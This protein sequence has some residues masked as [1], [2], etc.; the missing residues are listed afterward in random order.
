MDDEV[1]RRNDLR[2][3]PVWV[4]GMAWGIFGVFMV[5][6]AILYYAYRDTD[7]WYLWFGEPLKTRH[8]FAEAIRGSIFRTQ[9]NTWSNVGYVL[10][11]LYIVAYA[12]WD[13]R[14]ETSAHDPYAVRQPALMGMFGVA[15]IVLGIGSGLMHAAMT[16]WG[17]K[18]DVFG[19][20]ISMSMLIAL[21]WARWIPAVPFSRGCF[22][23]WPLLAVVAIVTSVLLVA[24]LRTLPG[25]IVMGTLIGMAVLGVVV[26]ALMRNASQQYRWSVLSLFSLALAYY[27]WNLD[28]SRQFTAPESWLQGHALWHLLTAV[29]LGSMAVF[30]RTETPITAAVEVRSLPRRAAA[31]TAR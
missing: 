21:Q 12:W 15:C 7:V 3:A 25:N 18:A 1:I 11:G 24:N 19:M 14:R 8:A 9:A 17:H 10:V 26:D 30:Y 6:L 28:R 22:P 5:A 16:G 2:S 27:I 13:A 23:T 20:F 29:T 4:H 31:E